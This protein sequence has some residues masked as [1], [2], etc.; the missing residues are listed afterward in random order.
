M[1]RRSIYTFLLG[2]PYTYFTRF[3]SSEIFAVLLLNTNTMMKW[4]ARIALFSTTLK[5]S[6]S[7]EATGLER[8]EGL[9]PSSQHSTWV[10]GTYGLAPTCAYSPASALECDVVRVSGVFAEDNTYWRYMRLRTA[11]QV[12]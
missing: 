9:R 7:Y 6:Q 11:M 10:A 1:W 4:L 3:S 8:K 5:Y 2:S 12:V